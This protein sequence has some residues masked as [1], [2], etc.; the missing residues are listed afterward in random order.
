MVSVYCIWC[1]YIQQEVEIR[2]YILLNNML[3]QNY[4]EEKERLKSAIEELQKELE[5]KTAMEEQFTIQVK[6]I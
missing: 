1:L 2:M 5:V 3:I 6:F 4:S